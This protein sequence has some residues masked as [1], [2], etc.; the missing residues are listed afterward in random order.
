MRVGYLDKTL[1]L[2]S[3]LTPLK[4][5]NMNHQNSQTHQDIFKTT[6]RHQET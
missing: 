2:K 6:K 3:I 1:P 4:L 5:A